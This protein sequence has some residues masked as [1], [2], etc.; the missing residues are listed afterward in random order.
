MAYYQSGQLLVS[1]LLAHT[2]PIEK[3]SVR[4]SSWR[5][6]FSLFSNDKQ[7]IVNQEEIFDHM[8]VIMG[9]RV[10]ELIIFN[11]L[12]THSEQDLISLTEMARQVVEQ[13]GMNDVV[14]N[15]SFSNDFKPYSRKLNATIDREINKLIDSATEKAHRAINENLQKLHLLANQLS[16]KER[17]DYEDI[18]RL[19][20]KPV[21]NPK[22]YYH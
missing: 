8:C 1:W 19:I 14:G 18:G 2:S 17:L 5:S 7:I 22:N 16:R 11:Q 15:R 12:S 9:G 3:V 21:A 20:G 4:G 10:A 6:K 13:Y